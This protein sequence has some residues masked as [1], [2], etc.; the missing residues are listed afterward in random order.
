MDRRDFL[1]AL[2]IGAAAVVI[3]WKLLRSSGGDSKAMLMPT[4]LGNVE[5]FTGVPVGYVFP[6][7]GKITDGAPDGWLACDGQD[8]KMREYPELWELI[9][10][11]YGGGY[12]TFK[13]PDM[14][15]RFEDRIY[16]Y[17]PETQTVAVS[18]IMR[19]RRA[20]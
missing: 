19:A 4:T 3:P 17:P 16:P 9:G 6:Y 10:N 12:S 14:N 1:K 11:T 18:Y 20:A 2:G 15:S 7:A 8:V 5:P 13:T